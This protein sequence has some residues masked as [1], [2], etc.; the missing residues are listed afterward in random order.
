MPTQMRWNHGGQ[1]SH[2]TQDFTWTAADQQCDQQIVHVS[3]F[4]SPMTSAGS[5]KAGSNSCS[6]GSAGCGSDV[7]ACAP[8][9]AVTSWF[10]TPSQFSHIVLH[11][12]RPMVYWIN[13]HITPTIDLFSSIH[14]SSTACYIMH[15]VYCILLL[16]LFMW[17]FS[18]S[19]LIN[20]YLD[21]RSHRP[22]VCV[23]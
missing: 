6:S 11:T 21:G 3:W 22:I 5:A 12:S 17:A 23:Q 9:T 8:V 10:V 16:R 15:T 18:I 19:S 4:A 14:K 20:I 7:A 13:I 1:W 2:P